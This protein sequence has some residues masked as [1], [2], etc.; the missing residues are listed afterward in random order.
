MAGFLDFVGQ[1]MDIIAGG[2]Q[3]RGRIAAAQARAAEAQAA[4]MQ[5]QAQS[6]VR[7]AQIEAEKQAQLMK[8]LGIYGLVGL[9]AFLLLAGRR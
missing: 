4:A 3:K 5:T 1:T 6:S 2:P 8:T 9:G 7:I